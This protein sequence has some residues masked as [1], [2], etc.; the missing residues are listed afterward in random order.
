MIVCVAESLAQ[1]GKAAPSSQ[2]PSIM[3][4]GA[5]MAEFLMLGLCK[6][7]IILFSVIACCLASPLVTADEF[8]IYG[9]WCGPGYPPDGENPEPKDVIDQACREHD[10]MYGRCEEATNPIFC[11]GKADLVLIDLLRAGI[12]D[13]NPIQ[14]AIAK[15]MIEYFISQG[16]TQIA[17]GA[18]K[19]IA[20]EVEKHPEILLAAPSL[21]PVYVG[22]KILSWFQKD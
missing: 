15:E 20:E 6:T 2:L 14:L 16:S 3:T 7:T 12:N 19:E 22:E 13:Y 18:P 1:A 17:V 11:R 8:P 10:G 21:I 5:S 9:N 4:I